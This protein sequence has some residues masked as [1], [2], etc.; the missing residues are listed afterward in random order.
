MFSDIDIFS[1]EEKQIV[2]NIVYINNN[3]LQMAQ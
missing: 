1:V 2:D 3:L